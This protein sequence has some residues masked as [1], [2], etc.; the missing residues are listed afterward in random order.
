MSIDNADNVHLCEICR[1]VK[2]A[3]EECT[4]NDEAPVCQVCLG[5]FTAGTAERVTAAVAAAV[6]K[7]KFRDMNSFQIV[8]TLPG[9]CTLR[10]VSLCAKRA[11]TSAQTM[12]V[13]RYACS[14]HRIDVREQ[15]RDAFVNA[16]HR[17]VDAVHTPDD[18]AYVIA[19]TFSIDN[20]D[21]CCELHCLCMRMHVHR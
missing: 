3:V 7:Y 15:C 20:L 1:R 19:L 18:D 5:L 11:C 6:D 21:E 8:F 13:R 16:V 17:A 14:V 10:Q 12:Y 2:S 9:S 4:S